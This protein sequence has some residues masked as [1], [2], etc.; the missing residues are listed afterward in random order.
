MVAFRVLRAG[1][2][3]L[4]DARP[5]EQGSDLSREVRMREE[6]VTG[7]ERA[8]V[9]VFYTGVPRAVS[10]SCTRHTSGDPASKSRLFV[11]YTVKLA[12]L[13]GKHRFGMGCHILRH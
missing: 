12:P 11:L 4:V 6:I 8:V 1:S 3:T 13:V 9:K 5:S 10:R 7:G 2:L